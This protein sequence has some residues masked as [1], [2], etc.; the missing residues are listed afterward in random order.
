M[1]ILTSVSLLLI[2]DCKLV[3]A[4][5][6]FN[7]LQYFSRSSIRSSYTSKPKIFPSASFKN[8]PS[9]F[10]GSEANSDIFSASKN[11][12]FAASRGIM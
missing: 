7:S 9:S 6:F 11:T 3:E 4:T 8:T 10:V 2:I 12:N 1:V 5:S